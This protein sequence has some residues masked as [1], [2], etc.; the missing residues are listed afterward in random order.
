MAIILYSFLQ[1]TYILSLTLFLLYKIFIN[2][3][4]ILILDFQVISSNIA[5]S[6]NIFINILKLNIFRVWTWGLI[7]WY[8]RFCVRWNSW[9]F[10]IYMDN[11]KFFAGLQIFFILK[12]V[13]IWYQFSILLILY[14][15]REALFVSLFFIRFNIWCIWACFA[16]NFP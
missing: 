13:S 1:W 9:T 15:I 6:R 14:N 3:I 10:H 12:W 8:I 7:I 5:V 11:I 16:L 2:L 4:F